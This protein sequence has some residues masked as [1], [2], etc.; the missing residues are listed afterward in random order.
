MDWK[1]PYLPYNQIREIA[2]DFLNRYNPEDELPVPIE[3]IIENQLN[4]D[5]IPINSLKV[6]FGT[7]GFISR[8]LKTITVGYDA[9]YK[10]EP[11][12]LFTLAHEIGHSI[13]HREFYEMAEFKTTEEWIQLINDIDPKEYSWFEKHGYDFA[14]LV[15]VPEHKLKID[16]FEAVK[17]IEQAGFDKSKN[18]DMFNEYVASF[19]TK[20]YNASEITIFKRIKYDNLQ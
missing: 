11:R 16:Y 6:A 14:G 17:E 18:P 5:I 15:L 13:M 12:Y 4:V 3:E 1:A 20:K 10:N 8:D 2:N 19:L 7:D 9:Y